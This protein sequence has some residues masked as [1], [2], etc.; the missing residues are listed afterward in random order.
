MLSF[1]KKWQRRIPKIIISCD[2]NG[3]PYYTNSSHLPV[4]YSDNIFNALDIEDQFQTLYTSGIVFH[5]FLGQII[6]S[7][8]TCINLVK[9][10]SDNYR[11]PYYTISPTY[12]ICKNHGYI[13]GKKKKCPICGNENEIYSRITGYYR[14]IKNWNVGKYP[15][16]IVLKNMS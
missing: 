5:S 16:L 7:W 12:S 8:K 14:P 10:I 11:L 4:D 6:S 3:V 13:N 15:N 2:T 1:S 9:K